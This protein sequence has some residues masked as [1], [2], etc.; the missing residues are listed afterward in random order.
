MGCHQRWQPSSLRVPTPT[1]V[2]VLLLASY[3]GIMQ[4]QGESA[5]LIQQ[6]MSVFLVGVFSQLTQEN[7]PG[8]GWG[9]RGRK[10]VSV[11]AVTPLLLPALARATLL[12]GCLSLK[13]GK[14]HKECCSP[15][16]C[17]WTNSKNLGEEE[18]TIKC[19]RRHRVLRACNAKAYGYLE[20]GKPLSWIFLES[21]RS[22]TH[23]SSVT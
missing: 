16:I 5:P 6:K 2:P 17:C 8:G 18:V 13:T 21:R 11:W 20:H 22:R 19:N 3:R 15:S 9:G 7:W 1:S 23:A 14:A 4:L 12:S 10:P